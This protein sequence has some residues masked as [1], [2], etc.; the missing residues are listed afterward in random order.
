MKKVIRLTALTIGAL[1]LVAAERPRSQ[2]SEDLARRQYE[3][4]RTFMQ[5]GRYTEALKDFQAVVESFA[6]S[7]VADDALL[8]IALYE[9]DVNA[10]YAAARAAVDRLLKEYPASDSAPMAYVVAGRLTMANS[11]AAADVDTA[12][13][14]FERVP[15]LF[16][17][18]AAVA[19]ARFYTGQT[20][21][22]VRR[23]D[24]ALQQ[25]RRVAVEY[26]RSVWAARA[27]LAAASNLVAADR[28]TEAF[29]RL[30]RI[31]QQF[32]GTPEAATAQNFNTILYRLYLRKPAPY[33]F[34]GR[35]VGGEKD[36]YRD[37]VGIA[38][39]DTGR[40][41]LGHRQGISI[42]DAKGT[43]VRNLPATEPSAF[44]LDG[45]D[46]VVVARGALL[47]PEKA[48]P[49]SMLVPV[50]G[51]APR[52]VEEIPAVL[53]LSNGDRLVADRKGR[54][55]IRVSAA[56]KYIGN[57]ASVNAERMARNQF[58]DIAM[59]NRDAKSVVVA[60][61]DGRTVSTIAAK[62]ANY[63][64]E[65]PADVA[66]DALGHLYVLDARKAA[67]YVFGAKNRLVATMSAA[68]REAGGL[69]K[70]RAMAL[71]AAGRLYVFDE[72]AQRIQVYQ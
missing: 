21:W 54:T 35:Y 7:A 25:F 13:A 61:R 43:L 62:G 60:D 53:T 34:S 56:G 19:A 22:L 31:R 20:L 2:S 64:F 5:N 8:E 32:P 70:P 27:D 66:F 41:L 4:G 46:R 48:A 24:E 29:G 1:A 3:S 30:Q 11:R 58:D 49:I 18:S 63:Q 26:P 6:K 10:D 39:D 55:V 40:V 38:I 28:A 72:S 47:L 45:R 14:S 65:D 57:F 67:I 37:V 9:A 15:R 23:T 36:R 12:L 71:D 42:F 16:P 33:S 51:K 44:F 69:Q 52:E 68:G 50:P 59:I 17:S